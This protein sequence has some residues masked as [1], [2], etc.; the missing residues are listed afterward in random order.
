[1][2]TSCLSL[3]LLFLSIGLQ[4]LHAQDDSNLV[5]N[6]SFE[7]YSRCP[8]RIDALGTMTIVEAW[9]QP[10]RG[11]SDYFNTCG[12]RETCVPR[13]K[14]GYQTTH[15]GNAYCGIYCSQEHYREYLQT[16]LKDSLQR[17]HHYR[18]SFWVS[19]SGKSP[20]S[21]STLGALFTST[22]IGDTTC[23]ILMHRETTSLGDERQTICTP[24]QP[25][26]VNTDGPL[27]NTGRWVEVAGHFEAHGGEKFLTIGNFYTFNRSGIYSTDN[28]TPI[29]P[30]AYYYIDDV[31]VVCTDCTPAPSKTADTV[32]V[33]ET[34][35]LFSVFFETDK[36]DLLPQSYSDLHHLLALLDSHPTM[37]IELLGHT[38]SQGTQEHN[39]RLS[40][41]RAHAVAEYLIQHGIDP[42]RLAWHGYGESHPIDSNATAEGRAHNRRVEYRITAL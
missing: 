25:Q 2:K 31:A 22:R 24:Y 20:Q 10:T 11:S 38:D 5:Y 29:L 4:P 16:E 37:K 7:D 17:G 26:V 34:T 21:V 9:W 30:G 15:S 27:D 39:L 1:M 35:I 18:V 12:A 13:N 33:G 19:L 41:A 40:E 3:L 14:M 32:A 42:G 23:E 6:P 28:P 8:D 36:S